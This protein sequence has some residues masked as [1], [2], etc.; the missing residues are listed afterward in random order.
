M[1][2]NPHLKRIRVDRFK[3]H[4]TNYRLPLL[5]ASKCSGWMER[6][7][8]GSSQPGTILEEVLEFPSQC[9]SD[10]VPL[11]YHFLRSK[12][13]VLAGGPA[14]KLIACSLVNNAAKSNLHRKALPRKGPPKK[15]SKSQQWYMYHCHHCQTHILGDVEAVKQHLLASQRHQQKAPKGRED[16]SPFLLLASILH[17]RNV[18]YM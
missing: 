10:K 15:C 17:K 8:E 4:K 16:E 6:W 1:T 7:I 3:G 11:L 14:D 12:P 5:E 9:F 13:D 18:T 2:G